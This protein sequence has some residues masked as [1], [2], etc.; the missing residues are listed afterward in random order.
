MEDE[1]GAGHGVLLHE[2]LAFV[3]LAEPEL[4]EE[5]LLDFFIL[6]EG[7]EGEVVSETLEDECLVG[8]AFFLGNLKEVLIDLVVVNASH[9]TNLSGL[10]FSLHGHIVTYSRM[11]S[12]RVLYSF[13]S[14]SELIRRLSFLSKDSITLIL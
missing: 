7:G 5:Q 2:V 1:E 11:V 3:D 4:F 12:C 10:A 9:C 14:I 6:D 8:D 13:R